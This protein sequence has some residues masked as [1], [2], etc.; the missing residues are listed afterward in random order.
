MGV[1]RYPAYT[2]H[3]RITFAELPAHW[4]V[5]R[6]R[7]VVRIQTGSGDTINAVPGG[8]YPFY[9][10]SDEPLRSDE[11]EFDT[12]AVLTAGDG[13]GVAK[14][15]HLVSGRFM[16]H[17]RVYVLDEFERVSPKFFYYA[18]S[19]MFWR[20]ALDGSARSTVDSVRRP[21][22]ADMPFPVPPAEEQS[23]IVYF[24]DRETARIDTLIAEQRRLVEG[25]LERRQAVISQCVFGLGVSETEGVSQRQLRTI[26]RHEAVEPLMERCPADWEIVRFKVAVQRLD[27]RNADLSLPMMSLTS[28]GHLVPRT[29]GRQEPDKK[30]LP[31]YLAV[32]P[33][34]LVVNPMW[35]IGG[36][37]GVSE[38]D[39]AVSPDY[40]VFRSRGVHSPRYLH[41]LLRSRPYIDQYLLYT[42]AHTT[43]DRRVQQ[44]DLDNLPLPVPPIEIQENIASQIDQQISRIDVLIAESE[45]F[46]ELA[47]ERRAALINATVTGQ[48]DVREVA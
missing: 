6:G 9:V 37:V 3:N 32:R 20:M 4:A 13:A 40:R 24:L 43:F 7:H 16:A 1:D 28:S 5:V 15:F 36:A 23:A 44:N 47:Q 41:H 46:I 19:S 38:V 27:V 33:G 42:R 22:I 35:L 2:K 45:R 48:I 30:N 10:R 25:L 18:F 14:V 12:T 11:W 26:G 31:R 8:K 34:D 21:M 29:S 17:Q 39:G